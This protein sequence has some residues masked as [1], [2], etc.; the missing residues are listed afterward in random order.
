MDKNLSKKI[1]LNLLRAK[2]EV[3]VQKI[4]EDNDIFNDRNN[5]QPINNQHNNKGV[6]ES[7]GLNPIRALI[8]KITNSIDAVIL[9]EAKEYYGVDSLESVR[10]L[11][12]SI[13][14]AIERFFKI[15]GGY[16][17]GLPK[18]FID[19][20]A[21]LIYVI[22]ENLENKT[23]N[24]Y[25]IDKGEGQKPEDFEKT[26]LKFGGNKEK[27]FF[28][29]GRFGLG[30][31]GVLRNCGDRGFQ[32]LL[33]KNFKNHLWG[34]TIIRKYIPLEKYYKQGH[35]EYFIP[36]K[37]FIPVFEDDDLFD[38][39]IEVL[40]YEKLDFKYFTHG[41]LIKLYNYSLPKINDVDRD[42]ARAL[43]R[44][45]PAPAI[46]YRILS[47]KDY[48]TK[49]H[50]GPGKEM[51]GNFFRLLNQQN[52]EEVEN[53][54]TQIKLPYLGEVDVNIYLSKFREGKESFINSE[55]I[56]TKEE[57]VFFIR[58]GQAHGEFGRDFLEDE[59]GLNYI[60]KDL[61]IYID[62][63][64]TPP[65]VFDD[66]FSPTR[67]LLAKN[68]KREEMEERLI[69]ILREIDWLKEKD[70]ERERFIINRKV[71]ISKDQE[72]IIRELVEKDPNVKKLLSGSK[73][74][75]DKSL[76]DKSGE[77]SQFSGKPIPTFLELNDKEVKSKGFKSLPVNRY[78]ILTLRTDAEKDYLK[79]RGKLIIRS[80]L[81]SKI[82]TSLNNGNL[83]I[84]IEVFRKDTSLIGK[85]EEVEFELTRPFDPVYNPNNTSL[86][87]K[88]KVKVISE[89]EPKVN[90]P[91]EPKQPKLKKINYP[92]YE[93]V[94]KNEMREEKYP[95]MLI[96]DTK[97]D[98]SRVLNKV[99]INDDF[100]FFKNY[101]KIGRFKEKTIV[102][103]KKI[104]YTA[105]W[106]SAIE[107]FKAYS[108]QSDDFKK[109]ELE[110]ILYFQGMT[111]PYVLFSLKNRYFMEK[112]EF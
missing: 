78:S 53:Y 52:N 29:H 95:C 72:E 17:A 28:V 83:K 87:I 43:N 75:L 100:E 40:G 89:E 88:V 102:S 85:E 9:K 13:P 105:L 4:L 92:P 99:L 25:I 12:N 77:N 66:I 23:G 10:N 49:G 11:P 18:S 6:I 94:S 2:N 70:K 24:V 36:N 26:F 107:I 61:V 37:S 38:Y 81:I 33:S 79:N 22:V 31:F 103:M 21:S 91:G 35:Y 41:T 46:P 32:L 5:W 57:A 93:V 54:G 44:Y 42:L 68:P 69:K 48:K 108:E 27:L 63:T 59:L 3:E 47:I 15:K 16:I 86:F 74:V 55:N 98:G 8:E 71:Q 7:Q 82:F 20:F 80:S 111:L 104:F 56:S 90:P 112:K 67:D 50:V 110:E 39:L 30:S 51:F 19:K 97:D 73:F 62:C 106:L 34:W 45:L 60:Q 14:E 109:E 96:I 58:N 76:I 101:L 65:A 64:D 1:F 84:G